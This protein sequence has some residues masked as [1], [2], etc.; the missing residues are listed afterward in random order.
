MNNTAREHGCHFLTLVNT[1]RGRGYLCT[2]LMWRK[3]E[4]GRKVGEGEKWKEEVGGG[5]E[6]MYWKGD[7]KTQHVV[8]GPKL[9][10]RLML[11]LG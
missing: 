6:G 8:I 4:N 11:L 7:S 9:K 10:L 3:G 5:R 1:A 2:A